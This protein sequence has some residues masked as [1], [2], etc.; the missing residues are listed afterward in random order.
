MPERIDEIIMYY[1]DVVKGLE[2][3]KDAK[4]TFDK[5]YE[6]AIYKNPS[7]RE[8]TLTQIAKECAK[9]NLKWNEIY[10]ENPHI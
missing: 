8:L 7:G 6:V 3:A 10:N 5:I 1:K 2:L 4:R 9:F